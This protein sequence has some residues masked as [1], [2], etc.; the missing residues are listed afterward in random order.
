MHAPLISKIFKFKNGD[1]VTPSKLF[2]SLIKPIL[3]YNSEVW[4]TASLPSY[5][6]NNKC[7]DFSN[8]NDLIEGVHLK[9]LK[10]CIGM[11]EYTSNWAV[12]TET[13]KTPLKIFIFGH[14]L[15]I[16]GT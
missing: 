16:G 5:P 13:G 9:F 11:N 6:Q 12:L 7:S 4:G 14:K 8:L 10:H 15:N 3:T 2:D 1:F